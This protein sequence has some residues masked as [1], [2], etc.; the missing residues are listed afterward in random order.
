MKYEKPSS[1]APF[2]LVGERTRFVNVPHAADLAHEI[3]HEDCYYLDRIPDGSM[4]FDVGACYGMFGL[5]MVVEK[6]CSAVMYE[7]S[8]LNWTVAGLNHHLNR[9]NFAPD[10]ALVFRTGIGGERRV[11]GDFSYHPGHPAGSGFLINTDQKEEVQV[12]RLSEEIAFRRDYRPVVV[13]LDCEGSEKE[14]FDQDPGFIDM[15]DVITMEWHY[16]AG[17]HCRDILLSKGFDVIITGC[18]LPRPPWNKDI[19]RG[20]LFAWKTGEHGAVTDRSEVPAA[21]GE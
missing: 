16:H 19:E 3:V 9:D 14:I 2:L 7:P 15:A 4:V 20:M 6:K 10:D 11:R 13:K 8:L 18:G 5:M 12:L 17:P 21:V 1:L